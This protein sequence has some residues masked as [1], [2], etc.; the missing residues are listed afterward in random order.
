MKNILFLLFIST[1]AFA[2][3]ITLSGY[4]QDSKTGEKLLGATIYNE[5]TKR[6][7]TTN[8][9][10][11]FSLE[12]PEGNTKIKISF[13]GYAPQTIEKK[14]QKS[15]TLN[16]ELNL[17]GLLQEVVVQG[18]SEK[19]QPIGKMSIPIETLKNL[20]S[21]MGE[22]DVIRALS[23]TPG[24][25]TGQ[26]GT[27]GLYVRGGSP[28]QNLILLDEAPIYNAAH[29]GGFFS[30]FNPNALKSMDVYKSGFPARFGGR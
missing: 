21:L 22:A 23:F 11:F 1:S 29:F 12:I 28:D 17:N 8:N 13:V 10:G 7:T 3:K 18:K 15:Q 9:Y 30:V 27:T 4:V 16:I 24:I 20:P 25:S 26:E 14:F 19:D 6:G 5:T 2:Q